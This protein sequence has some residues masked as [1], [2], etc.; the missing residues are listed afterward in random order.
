MEVMQ[1]EKILQSFQR[2][3]QAQIVSPLL[4]LSERV[5]K[6]VFPEERIYMEDRKTRRK[7]AG[8]LRLQPY[9]NLRSGIFPFAKENR[10]PV[11]ELLFLLLQGMLAA[12]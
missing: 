9:Q 12:S 6:V 5:G 10:P 8:I 3:F 7:R 4:P 2:V 1:Y 11:G